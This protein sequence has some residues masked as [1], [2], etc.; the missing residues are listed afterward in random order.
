MF[1]RRAA[2]P[3]ALPCKQVR[4]PC[5]VDRIGGSERI[6]QDKRLIARKRPASAH[7]FCQFFGLGEHA[8]NLGADHVN[9]VACVG[10]RNDHQRQRKQRCGDALFGPGARSFT[11][12]LDEP[13]PQ[14]PRNRD[15]RRGSDQIR[16]LPS[17][18]RSQSF[19][20]RGNERAIDFLH[21]CAGRRSE[22][23]L[24]KLDQDRVG[25]VDMLGKYAGIR[26]VDHVRKT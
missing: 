9:A 7:D 19:H 22:T 6:R 21:A 5:E 3:K 2:H 25:G 16:D 20:Q 24:R 10:R 26:N 23:R 18:S 1:N 11:P 17:V 15:R 4:Q 8:G 13:A 14:V 12:R